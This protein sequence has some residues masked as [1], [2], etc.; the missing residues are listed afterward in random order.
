VGRP[1]LLDRCLQ[2]L[3]HCD[4]SADEV[5]VV[6]QSGDPATAEVVTR[7]PRARIV[8][9]GGRGLA[10]ATNIGLRAARYDLVLVTADDCRVEP[11]WIATAV[12][13]YSRSRD[14][15]ITGRVMPGGDPSAVPSTRT[16]LLA[17]E[18]SGTTKLGVL[19]SSNMVASRSAL[20]AIGGFDERVTPSAEDNDFCYR[21]LKAGGRVRYAPD[22]VV[23]HEDWRTPTELER[24]YIDYARGQ[25]VFYAKHL[26]QGDLAIASLLARDLVGGLRSLASA[27]LKGRRRFTDPRRGVFPGL[28]AGLLEGWSRFG[29]S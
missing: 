24:L 17:R 5:L 12:A 23:T 11:A 22:L 26:R 15:I 20:L 25:G 27:A 2:S 21:W 16:D 7:Y 14:T 8:R 3:L 13:Q 4:P 19:Y 18:Y 29:R 10:R 6:D 9:D 28:L 1:Q